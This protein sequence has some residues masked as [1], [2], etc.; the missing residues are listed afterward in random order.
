M[1]RRADKAIIED[2]A[3]PV[4]SRVTFKASDKEYLPGQISNRKVAP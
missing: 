1:Y 4:S 2:L 3:H